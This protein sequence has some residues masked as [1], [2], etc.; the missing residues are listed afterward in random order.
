MITLY[1][2]SSNKHKFLEFR[3]MLEDLVNLRWLQVEYLEPQSDDLAE[4]AITSALWLSKYFPEPFFLEDAGLFI[5]ALDGFPGPYSSYIFN[6]LRNDGILKLMSGI[7]ERKAV[8]SSIIALYVR[9]S[10]ITFEGRVAGYIAEEKKR[11]G[12]GFDPIF[13]PEGSNGLAFGELGED[14]DRFSHRGRS[15]GE[16]RKFLMA[17]G[18][19]LKT[20]SGSQREKGE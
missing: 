1:F 15:A 2:A 13:I 7:E 19:Y 12:W 4:V 9:N 14:K 5:K 8:F 17:K 18:N 10:I 3:R 16:L 6:S 20:M 11:G